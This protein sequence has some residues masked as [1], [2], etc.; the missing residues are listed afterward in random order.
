MHLMQVLLR[1]E[2]VF[3]HSPPASLLAHHL[4]F[5]DL[6]KGSSSPG[7]P[8]QVMEALINQAFAEWPLSIK[9]SLCLL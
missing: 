7:P 2:V 3:P 6:V 5:A 8:S 9:E 4:G 1:T